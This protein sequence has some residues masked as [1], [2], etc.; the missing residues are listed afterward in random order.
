MIMGSNIY[1]NRIRVEDD[2]TCILEVT[3]K[4][5]GIVDFLFSP[6]DVDIISKYNWCVVKHGNHTYARTSDG[7]NLILHRVLLDPGPEFVV[8]HRDGNTLDN[9]RENIRV[10]THAENAINRTRSKFSNL[11]GIAYRKDSK[12]WR[13][14]VGLDKKRINIGTF[15]SLKE[16][17]IAY[18]EAA[19]YYYGEFAV[20]HEVPN[21]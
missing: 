13:A 9:R 7:S 20:L 4:K 18:N 11:R 5:Y 3:S 15:S 17:I 2:S 12:K 21:A 6:C 14:Y 1:F 8:D 16:A 10:C 19:L